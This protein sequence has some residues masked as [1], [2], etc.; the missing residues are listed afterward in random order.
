MDA[1]YAFGTLPGRRRLASG[2]GN[3]V[4]STSRTP[5]VGSLG[6]GGW[7]LAALRIFFGIVYLTN[8]LAKVTGTSGFSLGPWKS[9]LIN[10]DIARSILRHD[11]ASSIGPYHDLVFNVVLPHYSLFGAVLTVAEIAV[12]LGLITG[13][14]GRMAALG[15]ALLTLNIQIAA[16]G[17]GEWTYEYLV[18]LV[19]LLY[20]ATAPTGHLRLLDRVPGLAPLLTPHSARSQATAGARAR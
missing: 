17:G 19:P 11:A 18:E 15:G 12:G 10:Y 3:D 5:A 7:T 13:V 8:G 9:F 1:Q 6:P 4:M 14:F 2:I 20:L 16:L